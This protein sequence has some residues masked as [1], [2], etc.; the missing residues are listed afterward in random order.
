MKPFLP[1]PVAFVMMMLAGCTV[2][3]RYTRPTVPAAP[4]DAFKE[5]DGWKTAQ[6]SDQLLRG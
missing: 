2:G 4:T 1:I 3:P 6:P 5:T